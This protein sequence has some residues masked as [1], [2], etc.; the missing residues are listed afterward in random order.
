MPRWPGARLGNPRRI[1]RI[2]GPAAAGVFRYE[3]G[4]ATEA[5]S[6]LLGRAIGPPVRSFPLAAGGG[7]P[8]LSGRRGAAGDPPATQPQQLALVAARQA[9][10]AGSCACSP[11]PAAGKTTALRLLAEADPSALYP[12]L[13][14]GRP[15]SRRRPASRPACLPHRPQPGL[16]RQ[17]GMGERQQHRLERRLARRDVA[18]APSRPWS[19]P[20]AGCWALLPPSAPPCVPSTAPTAR[21]STSHLRDL[22]RG[23]DR[24]E[25]VLAWAHR[26]WGV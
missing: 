15:S 18:A 11:S 2:A 4:A 23:A 13:Q 14:Q 10:P 19:R 1:G 3:L 22:P 9:D 16:P 21:S 17:P 7:R 5:R 25:A 6:R 20:A 8:I 26:L 24:A 12:G